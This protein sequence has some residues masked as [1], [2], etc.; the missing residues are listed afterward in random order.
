MKTLK[1]I[2]LLVFATSTM[3]A[4]DLK[5]TEIPEVVKI[6]FMKEFPNATEVEWERD[7]EYYKV[8]FEVDWMDHE[9][10]YMEEGRMHRKEQEI[11]QEELPKAVLKEIELNYSE[12]FVEDVKVLWFDNNTTYKVELEN[13]EDSR[14][15]I[16]DV[17]GV[18]LE[19]RLD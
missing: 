16:F 13:G 12:Y 10:W 3:W 11:V 9:V 1:T 18:V 5:P 7:K 6:T 4:Q 15:I 14:K 17:D 19:E 8:E 2:L